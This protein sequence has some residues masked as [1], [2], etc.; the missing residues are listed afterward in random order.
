MKIML[1]CLGGDFAPKATIEGAKNALKSSATLNLVLLGKEEE[2]KEG[3]GNNFDPN[4]VEIIN[5]PESV[6]NT[7]HPALFLKQKPNSTLAVAYEQLRKREDIDAL[8]SAGPTGAILTGAVLRLG[9]IKG[10]ERPALVATLPTRTGKLVRIIDA[11]A[12][13]DSKSS[14]LVQFAIMADTYLKLNGVSNPRIGLLNVGAE[15]GKGNELAK[16]TYALLKQTNVNFIG[17]VEGDHVLKGEAD[18]VVCDGFWGNV[19]LKATEEACY[20]VSDLFKEAI[21]KNIF[22]KIGALFQLKGLKKVKEP[23]NYAKKACAPLLGTKKIVL[24]CHGK[25]NQETIKETILEA[26]RLAKD[27]LIEKLTNALNLNETE[28]SIHPTAK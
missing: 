3:L 25:S 10:V 7:D 1:D 20:Y 13:M 12:N 6:L 2:I 28:S 27:G 11:G 8:V 26:E 17:N 16:E 14:Y 21:F 5:A 19:F 18:A 9:R 15:E 23:F 24:K 4:R 22:T